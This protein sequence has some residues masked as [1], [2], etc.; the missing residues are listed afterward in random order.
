MTAIYETAYPRLPGNL[1]VGELKRLYIPSRKE[2]TWIKNRRLGD[3][4][5]LE[6][7][8]YLKCFQCLGYFPRSNDI[9]PAVVQHV[10][11]CLDKDRASVTRI[12][13]S[14][15]AGH[16]IKTAVRQY[17]SVKPFEPKTHGDWLQT[18]ATGIAVY[19][20]S[21]IDI[22]NAMIEM[23]VKECFELPAFSTLD[24]FAYR[25]K[26]SAHDQL[27]EHMANAISQPT[28]KMLA[29]LLIEKNDQG[30]TLWSD[31]KK[32]PAKPS[33]KTLSAFITHTR[34]VKEL[35]QSLGPIPDI[36]EQRRYQY[37]L[38]ARAY[39]ADRMREL[40]ADK[41]WS[42]MTIL[43]HEQLLFANDCLVDMFIRGMRRLHTASKKAQEAFQSRA[44]VESASLVTLL[45]DIAAVYTEDLT[46]TIEAKR[47]R[48]VLPDEPE[49]IVDR[50]DALVAQGTN[51]VLHFLP[52]RYTQPMRSAF[53]DVLDTISVRDIAG[54][55]ALLACLRFILHHRD[56]KFA[57]IQVSA[58]DS[59]I[60]STSTPPLGWV[61]DRWHKVLYVDSSPNIQN[62]TLRPA[63]FELCVF[64]EIARRFLSGDCYIDNS[65]KYD[66]YRH[67]LISDAVLEA[68]LPQFCAE[69]GLPLNSS[70]FVKSMKARLQEQA[71][72]TD[73]R[74]SDDVYVTL[75]SGRL[76]LK[77][78]PTRTTSVQ[79]ET[80]D[81]VIRQRLPDV[82]IVDVLADTIKWLP[83]KR[84][85][86]PYSG[87]QSKLLSF[88]KRLVA[89][90]FCYGCNLG[91]TQ[92][93][94]SIEG[95]SRKQVAYL[96]LN[97]ISES[98][99][100]NA[101][102][103]VVNAYNQYELPSYW[104]SGKAA[105][106]DG[107]RFDM[108]EQN[109]LS[110]YH[111]RYASYGGVGYYLVSDKYI[112]LFSRFIPCGVRE[113]VHLIDGL[114]ENESDIQPEQVHGDTHAQST[115][116]FGLAHLLGIKLMPRI[117]DI[118]ALIFFK[119]DRRHRYP[120]IDELFS[121]GINFDLLRRDYREML[122]VAISIKLGKVSASTIIRRLG[123]ESIRNSLFYGFRELGRV[124][125]TQFL[126]E[127]VADIEL[128][129]NVHAA[130]CKSEE[131]NN[132]LQWVFFYNSGMIQENLLHE[133][134]K[135]VKYNHLVAN[136]VI[137]HNVNAMTK[138]LKRLR[139]E[140]Y[141]V[142]PDALAGLS[143][144][145][146]QHINLLGTYQLHT[147]KR[148]PAQSFALF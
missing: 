148:A 43:I 105:S 10:S 142:T 68:E 7:L 42:L 77:Q 31:L 11:R 12:R 52:L 91:P 29:K 145:R 136:L 116:V 80:L 14:Q 47:I 4:L 24:R 32:E 55:T 147:N 125:R 139:R 28:K 137:L 133:Q 131:F 115:L 130:T 61:S 15:R 30:L 59:Y 41:R 119:P 2:R 39:N 106:V 13:P 90:L 78:R 112:A 99:L 75:E 50:C 38:E 36:P 35:Q 129:E 121:D 16:R 69:T 54:D 72:R 96:N 123:T 46:A 57:S 70:D 62:R 71:T 88:D 73:E 101:I 108:Y 56:E 122:R 135:L 18:F 67:H 114:M 144:Y 86:R 6:T 97:H 85:F 45:R 66:D 127:Y 89:T 53:L 64:S 104:G 82:N 19:K 140:G 27:F 83:M 134:S 49:T 21:T 111:I 1:S 146:H 5:S 65:V 22:I 100:V 76:V 74:F 132:F 48:D 128:R 120:H 98:D 3:A 37:L 34:W 118:N 26:T 81:A 107:T 103:A 8:V 92:T 84:F 51:N 124:V 113:A 87:H 138:V 20:S 9:P 141:E 60:G 110:E 63:L 44:A 23:L 95:L 40:R 17:L 79:T 58:L 143:P 33:T 126:L 102:T 117:K 25:A 93:A 94:R 109:L